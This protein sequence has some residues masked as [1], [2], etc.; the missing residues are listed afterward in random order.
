MENQEFLTKKYKKFG[1]ANLLGALK[2]SKGIQKN[3]ILEILSSRGQDISQY[4]FDK[5]EDITDKLKPKEIISDRKF[6]IEESSILTPEEQTILNAYELDNDNVIVDSDK[7]REEDDITIRIRAEKDELKAKVIEK[8]KKEKVVVKKTIIKKVIKPKVEEEV[9]DFNFKVG[10]EIE[11][12]PNKSID[13]IKG[14]IKK[15]YKCKHTKSV[16]LV[17]SSNKKNFLKRANAI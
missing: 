16:Y 2:N 13:K 7:E 9:S 3:V 17:I 4:S 14:I 5:I 8:Q 11:F 1:T 12:F 6:Y 10:E 15:I